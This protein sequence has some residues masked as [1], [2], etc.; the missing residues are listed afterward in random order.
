MDPIIIKDDFSIT[1]DDSYNNL[2]TIHFN[3]Y[4]ESLIK[5]VSKTK[6]LLGATCTNDFNSLTFKAN[7]V[8]TFKQFQKDHTKIYGSSTI[9]Y[10]ILLKMVKSLVYQLSYLI[11]ITSQTFIGYNPENIIVI[12]DDKFIYLSNEHLHNMEREYITITCPFEQKD[13][14]MSPEI[15][16]LNQIPSFV[17]YKCSYFSLGY[18][19]LVSLIGSDIDINTENPHFLIENLPIKG[20]QLYWLLKRCLDPEPK[21]RSIIFI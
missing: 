21:N 18:L 10:A 14:Y 9:C 1:Q 7:S 19:L 15:I 20:T 4:S 2:Y 13:F 16:K 8:K 6:I 3:S 17:H 5:S 11:S 12:N